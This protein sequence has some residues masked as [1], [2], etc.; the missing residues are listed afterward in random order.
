M[1]FLKMFVIEALRASGRPD[2]I[3][4]AK[5]IENAEQAAVKAIVR[6]IGG[7]FK[8]DGKITDQVSS[9]I[10][11]AKA[12]FSAGTDRPKS[13]PRVKSSSPLLDRYLELLDVIVE[14]GWWGDALLLQG[15]I[16]TAEC[17]SLWLF[18]P[19]K[20]PDV[21]KS[22]GIP[23]EPYILFRDSGVKIV[24]LDAVS[25]EKLRELNRKIGE[26][27]TSLLDSLETKDKDLVIVIYEHDV[28]LEV[29]KTEI[30]HG[31]KI[32]DK[33]SEYEVKKLIKER[34]GINKDFSG[35]SKLIQSLPVAIEER[36]YTIRRLDGLINS[37]P[38][39]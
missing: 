5:W 13:E 21:H 35:I 24:L 18:D 29:T 3:E 32:K 34:R 25:D 39:K 15:F 30:S 19:E 10:V 38:M 20:T 8:T 12:T 7:S 1:N 17:A 14:V 4:I 31:R 16:H 6:L 28:E 36:S 26:N 11:Q 9:Q 37:G 23:Y 22:I 33:V 2:L 27:R